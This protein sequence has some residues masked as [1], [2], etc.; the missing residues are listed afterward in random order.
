MVEE[1][2]NNNNAILPSFDSG[3]RTYC[4]FAQ[5]SPIPN[6]NDGRMT[7]PRNAM[8]L[9]NSLLPRSVPVFLHF[10]GQFASPQH[11]FGGRHFDRAKLGWQ[12]SQYE[13]A[14]HHIAH[15]I[16]AD[17]GKGELAQQYGGFSYAIA[18]KG[19]GRVDFQYLIS[20]K[21]RMNVTITDTNNPNYVTDDQIVQNI[22]ALITAYLQTLVFSQDTNGNFNGSPYDV[23]LIKNGLPQQPAANGNSRPLQPAFIAAHQ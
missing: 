22:A 5:R 11:L 17:N 1:E 18:F 2:E 16:R 12:P 13:T 6:I 15:I 7:T 14:I 3:N 19:S 20:P 10:D 8:P 9:V 4:T 21:Y 23:F